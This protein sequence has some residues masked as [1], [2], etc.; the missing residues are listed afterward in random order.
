MQIFL[1]LVT[2]FLGAILLLGITM[3]MF[4]LSKHSPIYFIPEQPWIIW[5]DVNASKLDLVSIATGLGVLIGAIGLTSFS[6]VTYKRQDTQDF[7]EL[8]NTLLRQHNELLNQIDEDELNKLNAEI[9]K[10]YLFNRVNNPQV[11]DNGIKLMAILQQW[12]QHNFQDKHYAEYLKKISHDLEH[13]TELLDAL[14]NAHDAIQN[15]KASGEERVIKAEIAFDKMQAFL[16]PQNRLDDTPRFEKQLKLLIDGNTSAKPY[17]IT[18]YRLLRF[19]AQSDKI[20]RDDKKEYFGLIRAAIPPK[21]LFL[22]LFNSKGWIKGQ[23]GYTYQ[24]LLRY[25]KLMEHLPVS[26]NWLM[27]LFEHGYTNGE[28]KVAVDL[29]ERTLDIGVQNYIFTESIHND[30]F[31]KS[32]YHLAWKAKR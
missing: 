31:G 11:V 8:F 29:A 28:Q 7:D 4:M 3:L 18:L 12:K 19:V 15:R 17:L 6:Y 26:T 13:E 16:Q 32:T 23:K 22:I 25:A 14:N 21:V 9:L 10:L 1:R 24:D 20:D 5:D 2:W 27:E 30:A